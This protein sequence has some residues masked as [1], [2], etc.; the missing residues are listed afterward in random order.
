MKKV[1][2]LLCAMLITFFS[3]EQDS[4][5]LIDEQ[6]FIELNSL[7]KSDILNLP[8]EDKVNYKRKHLL[9]IAKWISEQESELSEVFLE[10]YS[11]SENQI[12]Y[13]EDFYS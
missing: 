10:M 7:E 12:I 4:D 9:E 3:F 11:S 1:K 8:F 2:I 13:I 6:S 5:S